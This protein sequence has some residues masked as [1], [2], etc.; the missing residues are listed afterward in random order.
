MKICL[1]LVSLLGAAPFPPLKGGLL[2]PLLAQDLLEE[3]L[4]ENED[5]EANESA[6]AELTDR[7][8]DVQKVAREELLRL[9]FLSLRQI[10]GF[11]LARQ[12]RGRWANVEEALSA[13]GVSSDTLA[14]CRRIFQA[15]PE[16]KGTAVEI[17]ARLRIVQP[18]MR[19]ADWLGRAYRN[20]ESL[21]AAIGTVSIATLAER[22]AGEKSFTD[23]H[24]FALSWPVRSKYAQMHLQAG[25]FFVE[26]GQGLVLWGP[27]G[28]GTGSATNTAVRRQ[29]RGVRPYLSAN[30][31]FAFRGAA[32]DLKSS[33]GGFLLF[34]SRTRADAVLRDSATA[35]FVD[36]GGQHRTPSEQE[37]KDRLA[38]EAA[39]VG[40][41]LS[42]RTMAGGSTWRVGALLHRR[43]F[44]H[45][46]Q[47]L[48]HPSHF[49]EFSG[50]HNL[51]LSI[52]GEWNIRNCLLAAEWASAGEAGRAFQVAFETEAQPLSLAGALWRYAPDF[53]SSRG[54][55][56]AAFDTAPKNE[57]GKYLGLKLMLNPRLTLE[58][59]FQLREFPWRTASVPL[60][61]LTRDFGLTM[62]WTSAAWHLRM[63][64]RQRT[65]EQG[66]AVT[67]NAGNPILIPQQVRNALFEIRQELGPHVRLL[68][69]LDLRRQTSAVPAQPV[70]SSTA[71]QQGFALSQE[72]G[73]RPCHHFQLCVRVSF[74]ETPQGAAVY[75]YE[76]DLPGIITNFALREQ[77][78]RGYI[79]CSCEPVA[80]LL[81]SAK[82]SRNW[83]VGE[84]RAGDGL[85][86]GV[87]V[88]WQLDRSTKSR[89]DVRPVKRRR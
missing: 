19:S 87:Q 47:P 23:L 74:F 27:Y 1:V 35:S 14:L 30:E 79:F 88:D 33:R 7:P 29:A 71:P 25:D 41:Y 10:D 15:T 38:E 12:T 70:A 63:R 6:F 81:L 53:H 76:R 75:V 49:F 68:T 82:A 69:R 51:L 32:L 17:N 16:E 59:Y 62:E 60:P 73:W 85:S 52:F 46:I 61:T 48:Q 40:V 39:G 9:P 5:A 44:D 56:F 78:Q 86:W 45:A 18:A 8:L 24:L 3:K 72:V 64:L 26:W 55:A 57:Q 77:G 36:T 84:P 65:Q 58:S 20:Y 28:Q 83:R 42:S 2:R 89:A 37:K 50:R 66:L 67:E 11:L 22:D 80:G 4:H 31:D 54:R 43:Q 34:A 13:L 21:R